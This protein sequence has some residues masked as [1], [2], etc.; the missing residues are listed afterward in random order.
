MTPAELL[1]AA[2]KKRKITISPV[3]GRN[4][5]IDFWHAG[6]KTVDKHTGQN[7]IGNTKAAW[8]GTL[9]EAV[10]KLLAGRTTHKHVQDPDRIGPSLVEV[11]PV[12]SRTAKIR[13]RKARP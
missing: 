3:L 2:I 9:E 1:I 6:F 5:Q 10:E 13:R 8:G 12:P 7:Y 11:D 4:G